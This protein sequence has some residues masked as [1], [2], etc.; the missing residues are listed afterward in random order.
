M[1]LTRLIWLNSSRHAVASVQINDV[2]GTIYNVHQVLIAYTFVLKLK[3][4]A[5][6]LAATAAT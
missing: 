3:S 4:K 1:L 6:E 5:I 2:S